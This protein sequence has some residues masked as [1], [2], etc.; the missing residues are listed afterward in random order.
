MR[1][2]AQLNLEVI[3]MKKN[4]AGLRSGLFIFIFWGIFTPLWCTPMILFGR[5]I[6]LRK[7]F[8][9]IV[10]PYAIVLIF[11]VRWICGVRYH[12]TGKDNI[13]NQGGY[14]IASNHQCA[15]ETFFLQLIFTPQTQVIKQ[16]LLNI[17]FFGWA[18]RLQEPIAI[19]REEPKAALKKIVKQGKA[20]LEQ[21]YYVSI[22]PEGTRTEPHSVA[23]F[24]AGF[25]LL[26]KKSAVPVIPISLNPGHF[27]R[28]DSWIKYP[29]TVQVH[30]HPA[31]EI[32]NNKQDLQKI[33]QMV[34][35]KV[36]QQN[37]R[38]K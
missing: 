21:G 35:Q 15:W 29:G 36:Q 17:P 16:S 34:R 5:L 13:P 9:Y 31:Y 12:V 23:N 8:T 27:W 10:R 19:D 20:K 1:A 38:I 14:V 25:I 4:I 33:E 24:S 11:L 2:L 30:V 7:R 32:N 3:I 37:Q 26:A 22:F 28:N 18:F 6:P